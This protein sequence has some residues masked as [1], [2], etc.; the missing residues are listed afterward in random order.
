MNI[1]EI[2][3]PEL[4]AMLITMQK[5]MYMQGK[6]DCIDALLFAVN[7]VPEMNRERIIAFLEGILRDEKARELG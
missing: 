3:T 1:E 4:K 5:N 6:R 2:M 7:A